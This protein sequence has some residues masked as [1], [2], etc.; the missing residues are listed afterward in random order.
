MWIEGDSAKAASAQR[1]FANHEV[2]VLDSFVNGESVLDLLAKADV[3]IQFDLLVIDID[4]ND[5]W[6]WE[7]I[8][9]NHRPRVVVIEYSA[10]VGPTLQWV[11]P[12]TVV[13]NGMTPP[14]TARASPC[15]TASGVPS[16]TTW[17]AAIASSGYIGITV[18]N[19]ASIRIGEAPIGPTR[20]ASQWVASD[21]TAM[22][23]EPSRSIQPWWADPGDTCAQ[24]PRLTR[25]RPRSVP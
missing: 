7:K 21:G 20:I 1:S 14:C 5:A 19:R 18:T 11:M 10:A 8:A 2:T 17:L 12:T 23:V 4:G 13:T 25:H 22:P 15:W 6:I 16:A 24:L 9:R 3:S